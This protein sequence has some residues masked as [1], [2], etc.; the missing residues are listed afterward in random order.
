MLEEDRFYPE[1]PFLLQRA[2]FKDGIL[3]RERRVVNQR[4]L[5]ELVKIEKPAIITKSPQMIF[6]YK[7]VLI[8]VPPQLALLAADKPDPFWDWLISKY[9]N[10]KYIGLTLHDIQEHT[11][12]MPIILKKAVFVPKR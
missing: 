4:R 5:V 6:N 12:V 8:R 11:G 3:V 10:T 2:H 7:G 1:L 9:S